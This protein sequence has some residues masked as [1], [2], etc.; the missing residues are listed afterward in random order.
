MVN[1]KAVIKWMFSTTLFRKQTLFCISIFL[2]ACVLPFLN[3]R[4]NTYAESVAY[5]FWG[6]GLGYLNITELLRFIIIRLAPIYLMC[7]ALSATQRN[8]IFFKIR[9]YRYSEWQKAVERTVFYVILLFILLQFFSTCAFF[10][11][12][13]NGL[14][15]PSFDISN[16]QISFVLQLLIISASIL[17][18]YM[19]MLCFLNLY[20]FTANEVFSFI[21]LFILYFVVV[22]VP[23]KYYPFGMA[24]V[25]RLFSLASIPMMSFCIFALIT[26]LIISCLHLTL[27]YGTQ[28]LLLKG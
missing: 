3:M 20:V 24:S 27:K 12:Q 15:T 22:L 13:N 8:D 23:Y 5:A 16:Y 7:S 25:T 18:I 21:V 4:F 11:F 6:Y 10:L 26:L 14:S 9:L 2:A 1:K 17:E 19:A 28:K